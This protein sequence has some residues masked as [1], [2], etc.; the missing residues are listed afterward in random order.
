[1]PVLADETPAQQLECV[2]VFDVLVSLAAPVCT[3][4][5]ISHR[6]TEITKAIDLLR[7]NNFV[8][9]VE[10][11]EIDIA[12]CALNF[13]L[14][15]VPQANKIIID[16][17]L[18]HASTDTLA[19]VLIHELEHIKQMRTMGAIDFKCGYINALVDCGGCYDENHPLEAPAYQVQARVR[20]FLLSK[21]QQQFDS[22]DNQ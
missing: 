18:Q 7:E 5:D 3:I 12:F 17:G 10:F 15:L 1:M 19:E 2:R 8:S 4:P 13:G 11:Q 21:W 20:D 9:E 16:D 6:P 22:E 14:G